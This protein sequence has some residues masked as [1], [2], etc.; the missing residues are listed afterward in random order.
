MKLVIFG[1]REITDMSHLE[2]AI[3]AAGVLP[4]VTEIVSGGA[5][6]VDTLAIAYAKAHGLPYKIFPADW[7]KYGY[8]AGPLRNKQMANYADYGVAIWDGQS[9][10]TKNM[11][12][13]MS[14]RVSVL[15][16]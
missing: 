2:A 1:S 7:Q 6:G 15:K 10:G 9:R 16:I 13:L 14:G 5:R 3:E 11:I 8:R 12:D 4:Q